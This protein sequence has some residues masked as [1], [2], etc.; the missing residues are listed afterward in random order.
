MNIPE[1]TMWDAQIR[2]AFM[3][4][5]SAKFR[6]KIWSV[7]YIGLA[8]I[9]LLMLIATI[10]KRCQHMVVLPGVILHG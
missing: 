7:W 1:G 6:T 8:R 2:A 10:Q 9:F 3:R 5:P 4:R